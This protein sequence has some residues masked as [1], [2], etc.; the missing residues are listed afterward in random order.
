MFFEFFKVAGALELG[1]KK[2]LLRK[3]VT[4]F[5]NLAESCL[6]T[7]ACAYIWFWLPATGWL[8]NQA[9]EL[10]LEHACLPHLGE[11]RVQHMVSR[12]HGNTM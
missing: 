9:P 1:C 10:L 7:L 3:Q 4:T 12:L 5:I 11:I 6:L 8:P 2:S